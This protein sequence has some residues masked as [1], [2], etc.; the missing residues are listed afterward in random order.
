MP[1]TPE[2]SDL[3]CRACQM[4]DHGG[5]D[6]ARALLADHP[7][8]LLRLDKRCARSQALSP[9]ELVHAAKVRRD[10]H[11]SDAN[12][13]IRLAHQGQLTEARQAIVDGLADP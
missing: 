2:Q 6:N 1:L 7:E 13:I 4:L 8:L 11:A 5:A 3:Y 12:K 10:Q 9:R